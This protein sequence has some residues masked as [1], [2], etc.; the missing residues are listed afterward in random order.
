MNR[1]WIRCLLVLVALLALLGA[2][3][4][5]LYR[6]VGQDD[7]RQRVEREASAAIGVPV[8]LGRIRVDWLP[9]LAVALDDVQVQTQPALRAQ[10]VEAR[11]VW[12]A[13]LQGRAEVATLVVR[14]AVL[15]QAGIDALVT[16]L[17]RRRAASGAPARGPA[18]APSA[19]DAGA[20]AALWLPRRTVLDGLT[21]VSTKGVSTRLDAQARMDDAGLPNE[22]RLDITGGPYAGANVRID[23]VDPAPQAGASGAAAR[24]WR[25]DATIGGGHVRGSVTLALPSSPGREMAVSGE[26]HTQGVEVAALTAPSRLLSGKLE[27]TTRLQGRA[28]SPAGLAEAL[29]TQS[30]FTVKNAVVHGLDLLKAASRAGGQGGETALSELSGQVSTSGRAA[31]LTNLVARSGVLAAQGDVAVSAQQALSGRLVVDVTAGAAAGLTGIPLTVGGTVASPDVS[32][33]RSALL[34]AALGT[35]VAPGVGTGAGAKLGDTLGRGLSGLF[36]GK[37]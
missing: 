11:P 32:L 27:A 3:A 23:A 6:W 21:W 1:W 24:D 22:I 10:A 2:G 7:F 25:I 12:R 8:Q 13:L 20:A 34:G 28:A 18:S 5:A 16:A 29:R 19:V 36:G 4:L 9:V 26:L 31:Q 14:E 30:R 37:K 35:A 17:Q 15:P 33:S